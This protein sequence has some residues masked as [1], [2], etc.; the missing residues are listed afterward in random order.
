MKVKSNQEIFDF[1]KPYAD[2]QNI[3]LVEVE[4]KPGKNPSLTIYVDTEDGIDLVTL[5]K[6]HNLINDPLDE[7]DPTF[8]EPYT[9]NVSS[10]GLDRPFKTER[11]FMR[12][13]GEK[14]EVKL[15]APIKGN[16]F[17]EGVLTAFDENT[18]TI[19]IGDKEEKFEKSRIAKVN[20]A[21]EF[22]W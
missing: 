5:E 14:V 9:L 11:D 1:I 22:D 10:P 12:H 13:L 3:E 4:M 6:F 21:I 15:Y 19:L 18:V 7:F 2:S 16:K 17:F 8:N 20:V